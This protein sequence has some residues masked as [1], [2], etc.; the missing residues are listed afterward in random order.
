MSRLAFAALAAIAITVGG[1]LLV[2]ERTAYAATITVD[3]LN[4][5]VADDGECTL[6]EAIQNANDDADGQPNVDCAAGNPA[7][8]DLIVF[9]VS[10]TIVLSGEL[11]QVDG[12]LVID[13]GDEIEIDAASSSR[14]LALGAANLTLQSIILRNGQTD[15]AGGAIVGDD[16]G[17]LT[18]IDSSFIANN[19]P[20]GGVT[21]ETG[22]GGAIA[23]FSG[24]LLITGSTFTGNGAEADGGAI[25]AAESVDIT[26]SLFDDNSAAGNG[27]AIW[28]D[29]TGGT[30]QLDI[31]DVTFTSNRAAMSGGAVYSAVNTNIAS[32]TAEDNEAEEN[33]GAL[34]FNDWDLEVVDSTF[35]LNAA[36]ENGGAIHMFRGTADIQNS[37]FQ[38]NEAI[39]SGGA[40]SSDD[41][42]VEVLATAFEENVAGV[43]GGA[44]FGD[45]STLMVLLSEFNLNEATG[46]GGAIAVTDRFEA[47]IELHME[48]S[49]VSENTA[50]NGGGVFLGVDAETEITRSTLVANEAS[51][52]GGAIYNESDLAVWNSTLTDNVAVEEGG[53]LLNDGFVE[54]RN[55][56]FYGNAADDGGAIRTLEDSE[57]EIINTVVAASFEVDNCSFDEDPTGVDE[58]NISDD[59]SC[60]EPLFVEVEDVEL[61]EL[62]NNGGPTFTHLPADTSPLVDAGDSATCPD[63]DQR[64]EDRPVGGGCDIGAV[65]LQD[66]LTPTPTP[67]TTP[68]PTPSGDLFVPQIARDVEH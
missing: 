50:V 1:V 16:G 68:E 27:G 23:L 10:G 14:I 56:T 43:D 39:G 8:E 25:Y 60:G 7:G 45:A 53:A 52:H 64:D 51:Q 3:S 21:V 59:D 58:S 61:G 6:R 35:T 40:F 24:D 48:D 17:N 46:N 62:E 29:S 33:G 5:T 38:Q 66:P 30:A 57:T 47:G 54:L 19:A 42:T 44:Y 36:G 37:A 12:D 11:P 18:I 28:A 67:T 32:V 2:T 65:E 20:G 22:S 34:Y 63:N 9:S 4:D 41:A 13:G 31:T 15:E 55:A 49:T 26:D